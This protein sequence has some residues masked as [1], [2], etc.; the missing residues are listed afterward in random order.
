MNRLGIVKKCKFQMDKTR[1][2]I[3][4]AK[5]GKYVLKDVTKYYNLEKE[6]QIQES[7]EQHEN[8][9]ETSNDKS[10]E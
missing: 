9:M 3:K 8:N 10:N 1:S 5:S 2:N 6:I 7:Y 4:T